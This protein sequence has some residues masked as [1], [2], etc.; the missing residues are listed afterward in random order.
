ELIAVVAESVAGSHP[1]ALNKAIQQAVAQKTTVTVSFVKI[2]DDR[3][4]IKTSS[5]KI[6]RGA[7]REKWLGER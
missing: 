5:G 1:K 2:V 3:W 6:A 7:N 4:L